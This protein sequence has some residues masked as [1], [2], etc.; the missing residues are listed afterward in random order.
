VVLYVCV[1]LQRAEI[2]ANC[3]PQS[4]SYYFKNWGYLFNFILFHFTVCMQ[5]VAS[6]DLDMHHTTCR[7]GR[8]Q[9]VIV[10]FCH[11]DLGA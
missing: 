9:L 4:L 7:E 8:R 6:M 3:L 1:P 11:V 5:E 10:S 2:N